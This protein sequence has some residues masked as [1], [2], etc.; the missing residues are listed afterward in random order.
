MKRDYWQLVLERFEARQQDETYTSMCEKHIY[1]QGLPRPLLSRNQSACTWCP[2]VILKH[3][4][5]VLP[6]TKPDYESQKIGFS[7]VKL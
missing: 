1:F 7:Q 5:F 4:L 2:R 6:Q 3:L